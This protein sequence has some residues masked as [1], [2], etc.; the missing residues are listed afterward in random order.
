[1]NIA[2]VIPFLLIDDSGLVKTKNFKNRRYIGD[3]INAVKIFNEKEVDELVLL[4]IDASL[5]NKEPNYRLISEIASEAFMPI[6]YGGGVSKLEHFDKLFNIGVEKVSVNSALFENPD[7][8][9]KAINKFGSQSIIASI[10]FKKNFF[11]KYIAVSRC[12]TKKQKNSIE[13]IINL[14]KEIGFGELIINNIDFEGLMKGYDLDLIKKISRKLSIP[15]IA[16]GGAGCVADFESALKSG[17]S[18]VG[19]GSFF[20]YQG[21]HKAVLI[22]YINQE[23]IANISK[24]DLN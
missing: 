7:I 5:N 13:N 16:L 2:R 11:N 24:I 23:E 19:A 14:I 21:P 15:T 6:G 12:G 17:A 10:D 8:I 22:S 1:M 4:D 18:S 9:K 3:P 20:V